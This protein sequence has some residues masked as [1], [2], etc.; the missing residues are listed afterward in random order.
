M[1]RV[2]DGKRYAIGGTSGYRWLESE[3]V[4]TYGKE[5]DVDMSYYTSLVD[6]AASA[7]AEYG[8]LEWFCSDALPAPIPSAKEFMNPPEGEEEEVPWET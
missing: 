5:K 8:D 6:D 7:I 2:Q 4:K 3:V 1:Y